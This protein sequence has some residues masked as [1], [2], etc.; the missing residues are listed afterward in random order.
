M[1]DCGQILMCRPSYFGVEYVINPWMEGHVGRVRREVAAQQWETL[2]G[3]ISGLASVKVIDG[4]EH[5]PDMCFTANAGLAIGDRFVPTCFRVYQ[6]QPEIPLFSKWFDAAGYDIVELPTDSSFEG[7]GDALFQAQ[8]GNGPILWAG[9]G[10]RSSLESHGLIGELLNVD[11]VSLRLV[12]RRFYHLDTCFT[13]LDD[14]RVMYYP[15]AFDETSVREIHRRIPADHRL[16][17]SRAD[18]MRFVCNAL[19]LDQTIITNHASE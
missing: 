3:V 15:A 4:A 9:Y 16:E 6:R 10:V 19:V 11:V 12:D 8:C 17:V 5:M 14:C 2:H 7:E 13:P 1:S 18:A